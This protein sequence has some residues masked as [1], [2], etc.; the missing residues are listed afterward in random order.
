[1]TVS[2]FGIAHSA[3]GATVYGI[4]RNVSYGGVYASDIDAFEAYV[5][6]NLAHYAISCAE[7]GTASRF[8][9]AQTPFGSST[10]WAYQVDVNRVKVDFYAQA[11]GAPAEGDTWIGSQELNVKQA[12]GWT[13][14]P[15][16]YNVHLVTSWPDVKSISAIN[17]PGYKNI[18]RLLSELLRR[19]R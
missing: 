15:F 1:M 8:Y 13:V 7:K 9:E 14:T 19:R 3:T 10:Y 6:A 16:D 4:F 17:F 2:T 5:T 12:D 11:G 18:V